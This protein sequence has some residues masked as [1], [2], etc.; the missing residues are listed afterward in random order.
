MQARNSLKLA[1]KFLKKYVSSRRICL[2][3][4]KADDVIQSEAIENCV[5]IVISKV[6]PYLV[7]VTGSQTR[8]VS[9]PTCLVVEIK[10]SVLKWRVSKLRMMY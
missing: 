6:I 10:A 9:N 4:A 3:I 8:N 2:Y 7:K 1:V 5:I